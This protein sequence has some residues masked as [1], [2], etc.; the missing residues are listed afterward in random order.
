VNEVIAGE[1]ILQN[2]FS[3][4]LRALFETFFRAALVAFVVCA[5][6]NTYGNFI[7]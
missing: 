1:R 2:S 6:V 5:Q 7:L 3:S 4:I